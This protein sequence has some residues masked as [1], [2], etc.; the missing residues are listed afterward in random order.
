MLGN[1]RLVLFNLKI[2]EMKSVRFFKFFITAL[3]LCTAPIIKGG[4]PH[5]RNI[6]F[7]WGAGIGGNIDM[8][9][10]NLSSLGIDAEVG[11]SWKWIRFF[12][13]GVEGDFTVSASGHSYPV[14]VNFRTDFSNYN[15]PVFLDLRGG[16]AY[17]YLY[18]HDNT[19]AYFSGGMGIT[20]AHGRTFSSHVIL[21][22]TYL[23]NDICYK[24]V[25]ARNCPGI[26]MA[27][28]KLGINFNI[29]KSRK[30]IVAESNSEISKKEHRPLFINYASNRIEL[31]P[32]ADREKWIR[33]AHD[34]SSAVDSA[35]TIDIV[36]IGDSHIQAEIGTS[37]LREL[38]QK[39]Y[40]NGGRGLISPFYL[41]GTN[42]PVDYKIKAVLPI[43]SQ[44]R[45]L[46]RPWEITPGFTG[47]AASSNKANKIVFKNLNQPF[48][49]ARI[50]TS[51]G[52]RKVQYPA[53]VDSAFFYIFPEEKLYG[54]Y[55]LN[56]M[57]GLVYSTIGNN[58][59]CFSDYL[60]LDGFSES[61]A[62]FSPRL[63]V[64][65][66]GTNEGFSDMTDA[67][68]KSTTKELIAKLRQSN[69]EALFMLW[70]PMEC[71]K[72]DD[73]EVFR[74]NPRVKDAAEIMLDVAREEGIA[75]WNFYEVAGSDGCAQKWIDANLMNP[76]DHV[77]L[78]GAGYRLQGELAA[79]AFIDF[80]EKLN[81]EEKIEN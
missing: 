70:T 63:I 24:G 78:L 6:A 53:Q 29:E 67:E 9:Q 2:R 81:S 56:Q 28:L 46:K 52:E 38:L 13:V 23:G 32:T 33:F 27:T 8:S 21:A 76:R 73:K 80:I 41:A 25:T 69:P 44:V 42:Q 15:R 64:L 77:H 26:S 62:G 14:Y 20:L 65:S 30:N 79:E 5:T 16:V 51:E 7:S 50:F 74:V 3:L 36:H 45:L 11:L 49:Y 57:P 31:P 39:Q 60:L 59:A 37:K 10:H 68:I 35:E 66:M 55:T 12:G 47:V 48:S 61:V 4:V 72:K 18:N 43:D 17:N 19:G 1:E 34:L 40:G 71:H 22:Y 58:G 75:I 54:I